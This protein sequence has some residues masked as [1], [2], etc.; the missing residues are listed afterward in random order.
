MKHT[1]TNAIKIR[2]TL[3]GKVL[4]ALGLHEWETRFCHIGDE[5][6]EAGAIC[7]RCGAVHPNTVWTSTAKDEELLNKT[8]LA[9]LGITA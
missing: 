2:R 3:V 8:T 1:N 7:A 6:V 5:S 4:C 9:K